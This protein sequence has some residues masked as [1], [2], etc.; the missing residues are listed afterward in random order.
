[1]ANDNYELLQTVL[2]R[3]EEMRDA[4]TGLESRLSERCPIHSRRLDRI[5]LI[6]DGP[7][8][9]GSSPGLVARVLTIESA[10]ER[11][12]RAKAWAYGIG[13]AAIG[14]L[15]VTMIEKYL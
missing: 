1:M 3:V 9:N 13:G 5:E 6:L 8:A 11:I 10:I 15:I 12:H 2:I 14:G 4:L 7:P